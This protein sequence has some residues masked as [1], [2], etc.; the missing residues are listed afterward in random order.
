VSL[1]IYESGSL[2]TSA[3]AFVNQA[4]VPADPGTITLRYKKDAAATTVVTFPASPIVKDSAGNYHA[5]LDTSGFTGP[6]LQ[7]W[8][9]EWK[10]T[11]AVT[12]IGPDAWLVKP[13]LL[14]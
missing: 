1:T 3:A 6:G 8:F 13:P 5:D 14:P 10:G 2:V 7:Q 4:G 11:G 12:A 9:A